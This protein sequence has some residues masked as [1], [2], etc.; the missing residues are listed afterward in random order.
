M[1]YHV[2]E[3]FSWEEYSRKD[4]YKPENFGKEGFIHCCYREQLNGVLDRYFKNKVNLVVLFIDENLLQP[5]V[6]LEEGPTKELF[7]HVYGLINKEAVVK[8]ERIS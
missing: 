6:K 2:T 3:A 1:I 5:E 7:P 4:H 8:V